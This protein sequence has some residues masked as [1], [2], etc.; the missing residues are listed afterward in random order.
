[1]SE[2]R[3]SRIGRSPTIQDVARL[4][5]VSV[6]TVSAVI[7]ANVRVS[8]KRTELVREA[9]AVL[10]YQPD[11]RGRVLRT[12]RSRTIGVV[13][14]DVTNPF[15]PEILRDFEH[16]ARARGYSVLLCDSE[17]S[18]E[19][20]R[21]NLAQLAAR[22]VD[23]ALVACVSSKSTYDWLENRAL[24]LV[25]FERIPLAGRFAAVSTDHR[26]AAVQ[27]TRHFLDLGHRRVAFLLGD[28]TL[29][30][31][32]ARV[33]G[34]RHAMSGA[35]MPVRDN[36]IAPALFSA[37]DAIAAANSLLR[38]PDRPTAVLCS[39]SVLLL[40][41]ARAARD[42]GLRCPGDLSLVCFDNPSW[43][44]H[45]PPPITTMA[46]PTA[47]IAE[48]AIGMILH[49]IGAEPTDNIRWLSDRLIVRSS[50]GPAP[51]P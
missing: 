23:G 34:F 45:Y 7:N 40:G 5:G 47:E 48:A 36:L 9:M 38:Q 32:F 18:V 6:A 8:P 26:A 25:F 3:A 51:S 50:T 37:E 49:Q 28:P 30:S 24:P 17:N 44:A 14:P 29:S 35:V 27:A 13:V 21:A 20:E 12:G 19:Q 10:H 22:R 41:V 39:N 2:D 31:N 15:Y 1:M 46:Q 33:E 42:L 16:A 4:A 43:T 11:E